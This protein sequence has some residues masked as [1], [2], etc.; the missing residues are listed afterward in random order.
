MTCPAM[1]GVSGTPE[2]TAGRTRSAR[3]G[4]VIE[5]PMYA[6]LDSGQARLWDG[7][8]AAIGD[9]AAAA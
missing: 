1:T 6:A 5:H 2:S 9:Q 3:R 8:L 4:A 7:I